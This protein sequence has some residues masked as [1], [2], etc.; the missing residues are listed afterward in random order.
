[1]TEGQAEEFFGRKVCQV[2]HILIRLAM[3]DEPPPE[4]L[5]G[6]PA[7][8]DL[9][10]FAIE[11]TPHIVPVQRGC[12]L[13]ILPDQVVWIVENIKR[14]WALTTEGWCFADE[15]EALYFKMAF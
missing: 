8:A 12:D 11:P 10:R 15:T 5:R 9:P 7:L 4:W 3:R 13:S 2:N 6:R 14:G 1:M